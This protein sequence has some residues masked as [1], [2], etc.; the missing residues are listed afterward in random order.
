MDLEAELSQMSQGNEI[1]ALEDGFV[2]VARE[3]AERKGIT[4]A[5]WREAGVSAGVLK[6]AGIG[7]GAV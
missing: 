1:S 6:R 3:Y 5:T 4:Y 7:R 2:A